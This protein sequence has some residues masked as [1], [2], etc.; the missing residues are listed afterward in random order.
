LIGEAQWV[1]AH[2]LCS[3]LGGAWRLP[4]N[5][6]LV[7]LGMTSIAEIPEVVFG[8]KPVSYLSVDDTRDFPV[9]V[10]LAPV[11]VSHINLAADEKSAVICVRRPPEWL[12]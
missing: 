10:H 9:Y 4:K 3:A 2:G 5:F 1:Q 12:E 7:K 11:V 8:K 6:E